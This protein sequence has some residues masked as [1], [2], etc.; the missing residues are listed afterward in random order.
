MLEDVREISESALRAPII[1]NLCAYLKF[2]VQSMVV[3][4]KAPD[5]FHASPAPQLGVIRVDSCRSTM[6]DLNGHGAVK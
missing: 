3:I 6:D 2:H 5:K 4:F 1:D